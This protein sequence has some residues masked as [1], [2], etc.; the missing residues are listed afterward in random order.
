[1]TALTLVLIFV[2]GVLV[3]LIVGVV[4]ARLRMGR[5]PDTVRDLRKPAAKPP[6]TKPPAAPQTVSAAAALDDDAFRQRLL[7][8]AA[9]GHL[10]EAIKLF[11][12]RTGLGLKESKDVI[13]ALAAGA[14]RHEVLARLPPTLADAVDDEAFVAQMRGLLAAGHKI[15]AIKLFRERT[16]FG[17]KEAKDAVEAMVRGN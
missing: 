5:R 3:T 9:D 1:M 16:G 10:V 14:V 15:E 4:I 17:L 8:Q 11:R 7:A 12:Q 6:A 2:F 13:E